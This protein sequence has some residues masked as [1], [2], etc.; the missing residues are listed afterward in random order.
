[1]FTT[2]RQSKKVWIILMAVMALLLC[3]LVPKP[4]TRDGQFIADHEATIKELIWEN[5][6]PDKSHIKTI[7]LQP[8]TA[9]GGFEGSISRHYYINFLAF[10]NDDRG[11]KILGEVGFPGTWM[12]YFSFIEPDPY[13]GEGQDMSTW[14]VTA[15][16][17]NASQWQWKIDEEQQIYQAEQ[18]ADE[19]R[20]QKIEQNIERFTPL[21]R[22]WVKLHEPSLKQVIYDVLLKE[23]PE[24][25]KDLGELLS[26]EVDRI[27]NIQEDRRGMNVIFLLRFS[28][29]PEDVAVFRTSLFF[30]DISFQE[31]D[32]GGEMTFIDTYYNIEF[33]IGSEAA[34]AVK[35][36]TGEVII[37]EVD[38]EIF[39]ID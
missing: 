31:M 10:A 27:Y 19:I 15:E 34:E 23:E 33:D 17:T 22:E 16:R 13:T 1:M 39:R 36:V 28:H 20:W 21:V 8:S 3:V 11:Y 4:L 7:T 12:G 5:L 2:L 18:Q 6:D 26:L 29:Y 14:F 38:D 9:R 37:R 25:A 35:L 24:T 30:D 32:K